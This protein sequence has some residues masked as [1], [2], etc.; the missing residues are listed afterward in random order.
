MKLLDVNSPWIRTYFICTIVYY[1]SNYQYAYF[2]IFRYIMILYSKINE[3]H[4]NLTDML[5]NPGDH[6]FFFSGIIGQIEAILTVPIDVNPQYIAILGHP[7]SLQGGTMHNKVVTTLVRTFKE[8]GIASIRFNFRGV[9]LSAGE[10]DAGIGESDDMLLFARQ[11]QQEK[12]D[13]IILFA[14]FS[15]GSYV[16]YRAAAQ[17]K[18]G[19][20]ITVAPSVQ[21]YDYTEF[22]PAP[23]PWIIAQA[24]M[25]E[26]VPASQI[27]TFAE[28]HPAIQRLCFPDTS[29]FFHGKLIL[30]KER[31][32]EAMHTYDLN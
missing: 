22:T 7:H 1:L 21:H 18:H 29:H 5:K 2:V 19:L 26:V 13:T 9:G 27:Q 14:G 8:L 16:A 6:A 31:L 12:P 15:F 4:M 25:D 24:D 11:W 10:Y 28:Q 17:C 30:L 20:L 32:L 3:S 23:T